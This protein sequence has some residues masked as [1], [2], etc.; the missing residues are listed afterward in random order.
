MNF[1]DNAFVLAALNYGADPRGRVGSRPRFE[2]YS[3]KSTKDATTVPT[4]D[5]SLASLASCVNNLTKSN[6]TSVSRKASHAEVKTVS[7][8]SRVSIHTYYHSNRNRLLS[9]WSKAA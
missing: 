1:D 4:A 3:Y 8:S 6:T 7:V 9:F 5:T 2:P